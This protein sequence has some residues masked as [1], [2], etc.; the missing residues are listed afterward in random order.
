[1]VNYDM[2]WRQLNKKDNETNNEV[3]DLLTKCQMM[4]LKK[5]YIFIFNTRPQKKAE[6]KSALVMRLRLPCRKVITKKITK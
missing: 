1:M 6:L 2:R 4:N 5:K 3:K